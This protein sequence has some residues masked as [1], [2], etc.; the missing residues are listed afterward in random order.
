M[1]RA[2]ATSGGVQV[3]S[4]SWPLALSTPESPETG[5]R[6]SGRALLAA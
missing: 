1:S 2:F 5:T 6:L 3:G 4:G